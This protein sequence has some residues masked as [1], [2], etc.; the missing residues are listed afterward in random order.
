MKRLSILAGAAACA[1]TLGAA[2]VPAAAKSGDAV[3][4]VVAGLDG[5]RGLATVRPGA[6]LVSESDGTVSLVRERRH[7]PATVRELTSVP[8]NFAPAIALGRGGTVYILTGASGPPEE[9]P[10]PVDEAIAEASSKLFKWR[11]GWSHPRLLADIGAYQATHTDPYDLENQPEESNPFGVTALRRGA[12]LVADAAGNDLLRVSRHGHITTVAV[13]KPRT[14][15]VPE[16][17][18]PPAGTEMPAESVPTSVVVGSDGAYYV[19]ELRGFPA[20]PGTSQVWRIERG[21]RGAVCDP[22]RPRR[23]A[24]TRYAD[25]LTSVVDLAAGKHGSIYALTLSKQSW[26]AVE[27]Q[28]PVPGAEIGGLVK[29][30]RHGHRV[31]ELAEDRLVLPGGVDTDRR[32]GVYVVGPVFG[33]GALLE[34]RH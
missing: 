18:G 23:G 32:G 11:P 33:P 15:E 5:P 10:E 19:G 25:G 12:V 30:T 2:V 8:A 9:G 4:T 24:C 16:G 31:R 20:T 28:P 21:S 6:T 13:F 26:L 1:L 3:R 17:V 22:E 34:V 29:I 7:R 14:V 27:S